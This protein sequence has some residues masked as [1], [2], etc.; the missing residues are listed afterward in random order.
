[1]ND[2]GTQRV[3]LVE[4]S[5]RPGDVILMNGG[6]KS[7]RIISFFD[8]GPYSHAA[9]YIGEGKIYQAD[10]NGVADA[11]LPFV[12]VKIGEEV[13]QWRYLESYKGQA[14]VLRH[15]VLESIDTAEVRAA[16]EAIRAKYMY[17]PY[18]KFH[19]L[20]GPLRW[21]WPLRWIA[22]RVLKLMWSD[23]AERARRI[24]GVFCSELVAL[25]FETLG[26]NIFPDRLDAVNVGPND[27]V[28]SN[29]N[30]V[31]CVVP[32]QVARSTPFES[33]EFVD[34]TL[35]RR[36]KDTHRLLSVLKEDE[37]RSKEIEAEQAKKRKEVVAI[38]LRKFDETA[39]LLSKH[40]E[41]GLIKGAIEKDTKKLKWFGATKKVLRECVGPARAAILHR[42]Y[43]EEKHT[44]A[45][46]Q[47]RTVQFRLMR[48][49][50]RDKV[51]L[52][53][54]S[55]PKTLIGLVRRWFLARRSR[56]LYMAFKVGFD[57]DRKNLLE[58]AEQLRKAHLDPGWEREY[59][60]SIRRQLPDGWGE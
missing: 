58:R 34:P 1:M 59:I 37:E 50:L 20:A 56:R 54:D 32:D 51:Q 9:L 3:Y 40:I 47:F 38:E 60:D 36:M 11:L 48:R 57:A 28:T 49:W 17:D 33:E 4:R 31:F 21:P 41:S 16:L 15:P 27:F 14:L 5:L 45:A 23:K 46:L 29:L 7:S 25:F 13:V 2:G 55:N 12:R 44:R 24:E 6:E 26:L 10:D 53:R 19:R 52:E 22:G 30:H 43:E 8:G 35:E 42:R 39:S 18:S